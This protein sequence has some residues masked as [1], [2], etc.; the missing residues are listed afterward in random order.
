LNFQTLFELDINPGGTAEWVRLGDGLT[1]GAPNNNEVLDQKKYLSGGGFGTTNVIGAQ[2]IYTFA[3]DRIP[4]DAGQDY[5]LSKIFALGNARK[6]NFR[7]TG[8]DGG[9]ITGP[10]T[11]VITNPGG[12]DAAAVKG[13]GFDI[14]L[15]GKPTYTA[16]AAGAA[17]TATIAAGTA[18]GT[19]KATA[20][21]GADTHLGYVLSAQVITAKG[22]QFVAEYTPY[23]SA[24]DIPAASG[25]YLTVYELDEYDHL[26]KYASEVLAS[27]D[28]AA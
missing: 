22:R 16:P 11:I 3:G 4:G 9:I 26:V 19:T 8:E 20:T 7:S 21:A 25:Q 14:H 2:L 1:S 5:I 10:C 15:N 12:G 17:L 24:A 18:S 23:T 27:G 6:T 28:I 13:I